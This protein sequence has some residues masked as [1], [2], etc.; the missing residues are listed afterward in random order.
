VTV[1]IRICLSVSTCIQERKVIESSSCMH[2]AQIP[3]STHNFQYHIE[4]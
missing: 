1:S 4:V 3:H 2:I